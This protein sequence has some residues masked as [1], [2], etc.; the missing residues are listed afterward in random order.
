MEIQVSSPARSLKQLTVNQLCDL[1]VRAKTLNEL[2]QSNEPS[3]IKM[4]RNVDNG[5]KI[6]R[7][8][9]ALEV[10]RMV[11]LLKADLQKQHVLYMV[12]YILKH[13]NGYTISDLTIITDSLVRYNPYGKPI[14]QNLIYELDQYSIQR[15]EHAV[16]QNIKANAKHKQQ[17]A[18]DAQATAIILKKYEAMK[19]KAREPKKSRKQKD[20]EAI[21]ANAE[22]IKTLKSLYPENK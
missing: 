9:I 13:Y 7:S 3:F 18:E 15:D 5:E 20:E 22:K 11:D 8:L 4:I 6:V 2:W 21:A 14:L 17:L 19:R 16:N 1:S 12:D 10:T